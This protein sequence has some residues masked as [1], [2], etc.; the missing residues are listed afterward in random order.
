MKKTIAYLLIALFSIAYSYETVGYFAKM[1]K[2]SAAVSSADNDSE[3]ENNESE[4]EED[5]EKCAKNEFHHNALFQPVFLNGQNAVSHWLLVKQIRFTSSDF[6]RG[7]DFPP[8]Q[9]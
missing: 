7:I 1:A 4:S 2:T 6:S 5:F 9:A 8:E 3:N